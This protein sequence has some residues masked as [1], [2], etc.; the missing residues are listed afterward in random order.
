[1]GDA[2]AE[3]EMIGIFFDADHLVNCGDVDDHV[4]LHEPHVEQRPERLAAGEHFR[5]D[6]FASQQ[7]EGRTQIAR[8]LIVETRRFHAGTPAVSACFDFA[9]E[10]AWSTRRGVTGET[11]SSAP[12]PFS[13]SLTAL[14][15]AAG[16]AMAP[17]SPMPFWPKRV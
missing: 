7:C 5:G 14:V 16:G 4:R 1:M 12:S 6:I 13:A 11:E 3:H 17:P 10:I 8:A 15:I 9:A 2:G